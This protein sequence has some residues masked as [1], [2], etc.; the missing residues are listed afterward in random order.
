MKVKVPDL[1]SIWAILLNS[2]HPDTYPQNNV[3]VSEKA[4][5][6]AGDL[7]LLEG[8]YT[9]N[10]FISLEIESMNNG[11]L[12]MKLGAFRMEAY[13]YPSTEGGFTS[14]TGD[15][16]ISFNKDESGAVTGLSAAIFGNEVPAQKAQ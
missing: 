16:D 14:V 8:E 3:Y 4:R 5:E 13:L 12:L 11:V 9:V 7:S 6:G 10:P 2:R 15:I 1:G